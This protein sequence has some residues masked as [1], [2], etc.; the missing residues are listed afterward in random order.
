MARHRNRLLLLPRAGDSLRHGHDHPPVHRGVDPRGRPRHRDFPLVSPDPRPHEG[1]QQ[2][3]R[4]PRGADGLAAS[5]GVT[6]T[7]VEPDS[8]AAKAGLR[9]GD[10][11]VAFGGSPIAGIDDLQRMLTA[12]HIDRRLEMTILRGTEKLSATIVPAE[13]NRGAASEYERSSRP[14]R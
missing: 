3:G 13:S 14:G 7:A 5:G 1:S 10:I 11:V 9:P 4:D 8:P 6:V 12:E 2:R